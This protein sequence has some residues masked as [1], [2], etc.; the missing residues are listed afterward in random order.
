MKQ[1]TIRITKEFKFEM[2]HALKGYD[3]PCKNI[4]GHSY[5]LSVTISGKPI[6]DENNPKLGM[7]MDFGELKQIIKREVVDLFD[8]ALVLNNSMDTDLLKSLSKNFEKVILTDYQ[9]TSEMMI[10]DFASRISS[11]LP[12]HV[13]LKYLLL[14]ETVTSFAEWYADEN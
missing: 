13:T 11:E 9:P 14:R 2:A 3:G 8:H 10:I 12:S 1:S 5:E 4:H 7:V 6:N